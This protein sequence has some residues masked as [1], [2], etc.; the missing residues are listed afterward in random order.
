VYLFEWLVFL[1]D[2]RLRSERKARVAILG[3]IHGGEVLR[4]ENVTAGAGLEQRRA[5]G[6][7]VADG[8]LVERR[9]ARLVA[10]VGIG[11][12]REQQL[13]G[14][15][16]AAARSPVQRRLVD[17]VDLVDLNRLLRVVPKLDQQLVL[18]LLGRV[19]EARRTNQLALLRHTG[20]P[21]A[22]LGHCE[23]TGWDCVLSRSN[24]RRS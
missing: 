3:E 11:A 1:F 6:S 23:R 19:N 5:A 13:D 8:G 20:E 14:R 2:Q 15:E 22:F 12:P 9:L 4:V 18:A 7:I 16:V 24:S 21:I 17:R 10:E